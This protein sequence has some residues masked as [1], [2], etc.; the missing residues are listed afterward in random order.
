MHLIVSSFCHIKHFYMQ[1]YTQSK[2]LWGVT[3]KVGKGYSLNVL[4]AILETYRSW[5]RP[6]ALPGGGDCPDLESQGCH[7]EGEKECSFLKKHAIWGKCREPV[8][9]LVVC[10]SHLVGTELRDQD[11][12]DTDENEEINL[13]ERKKKKQGD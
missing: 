1:V 3:P 7:R 12:N 6:Q 10:V 2:L 13:K 4:M 5:C 8:P 11:L 9:K